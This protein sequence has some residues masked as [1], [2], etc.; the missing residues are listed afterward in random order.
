MNNGKHK[1][2][3]GNI[4]T[5]H[6]LADYIPD[7][8][9]ENQT[10]FAEKKLKSLLFRIAKYFLGSSKRKFLS[11]ITAKKL[12]QIRKLH[13]KEMKASGVDYSIALMLDYS[14]SAPVAKKEKLACYTTILNDTAESCAHNPFQFYLFHY[15]DP[16]YGVSKDMILGKTEYEIE[17]NNEKLIVPETTA[18]I[19]LLLARKPT[20]GRYKPTT[21][22]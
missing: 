13:L 21:S 11:L 10:D 15:F 9:F 1:P 14:M 18:A 2:A 20:H 6:F 22:I 4:H 8:L 19:R 17:V 12:K 16:R 3:I 5:H 7:S